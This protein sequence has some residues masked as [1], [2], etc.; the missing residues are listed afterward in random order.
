MGD[1]LFEISEVEQDGLHVELVAQPAIGYALVVN[2]VPIV[3]RLTLTN[4]SEHSAH[5]V[6]LAL[7]IAG[8]QGPIASLWTVH[9]STPV[10]PG[11]SVS[12]ED[13]GTATADNPQ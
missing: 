1:R 13:F 5:D 8:P 9:L 10:A 4:R 2:R 3:R 11:R 6:T 7:A 12:W